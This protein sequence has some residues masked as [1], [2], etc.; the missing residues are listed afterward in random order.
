VW[1]EGTQVQRVSSLKRRK[2]VVSG[3][4]GGA[5]GHAIKGTAKRMEEKSSAHPTTKS[6]GALQRG[7]SR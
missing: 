1:R 2:E 7:H 6:T 5:Y 3:R 4:R